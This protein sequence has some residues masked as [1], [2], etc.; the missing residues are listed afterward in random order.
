MN[1]SLAILNALLLPMVAVAVFLAARAQVNRWR[2]ILYWLLFGAL[3]LFTYGYTGSLF[4]IVTLADWARVYFRLAVTVAF[5]AIGGLA[6]LDW[7]R[8]N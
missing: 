6:Y 3:V 1:D 4:E 5:V 2:S 7:R 8:W